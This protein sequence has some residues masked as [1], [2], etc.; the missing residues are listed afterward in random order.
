MRCALN[1]QKDCRF[2]VWTNSGWQCTWPVAS[3][4]KVMLAVAVKLGPY[5]LAV[6][7]TSRPTLGE[8]SDA[9]TS[10]LMYSSKPSPSVSLGHHQMWIQPKHFCSMLQGHAKRIISC[11]SGFQR[12]QWHQRENFMYTASSSLRMDDAG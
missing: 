12:T 9:D 8:A 1:L 2:L 5:R 6:W 10:W 3:L 11:T 7:L 4:E